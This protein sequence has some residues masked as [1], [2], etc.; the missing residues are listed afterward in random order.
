MSEKERLGFETCAIHTGQQPERETGAVVTPVHLTSTYVHDAPGAHRGYEYTRSGNPT[1][2]AFEE[3]LASLER[4]S[5][6]FAFASGTQASATLMQLL[7]VGDHVVCCDDM[8]GGTHRMFEQVY[9]RFGLSFSYADLTDPACFDEFVRDETAMVWLE[10]PSNPLMKLVDITAIAERAR[11]RGVLVVVDNTFLS[12]YFQQ[13]LALGADLVMH[14]TTKYIGGHSDLVGG[15]VVAKNEELAERVAFLSN[16]TGGAQS[17]FDAYLCLRSLKTLA[18]RMQA[19]ERSATAI[20]RY[21][22][23]H[24]GVKR[25]YYPGL[26]EHPQFELAMRQS[27]GHG[28]TLSFEMDADLE[29]ICRALSRF[30]LFTLAESLG[31]VESLVEHPGLMTHASMPAELRESVGIG[32]GLVRMSVGLETLDDLIADIDQAL[33]G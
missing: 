2:T 1:R 20:A 4:G 32:D 5:R 15:A 13:P 6:G 33:A 8:Y 18:V 21:L 28:G 14:S 31:G 11:A 27:S 30:E 16:A 26:P 23:S 24:P 19:H 29:E 3:C 17:P 10:S 25:V 7:K 9:T 22:C 12:P